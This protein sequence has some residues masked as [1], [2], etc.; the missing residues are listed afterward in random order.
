MAAAAPP[1]SPSPAPP[2]RAA[3]MFAAPYSRS[4]S[5]LGSAAKSPLADRTN[6]ILGASERE[7]ERKR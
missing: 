1:A 2:A 3:A 7:R 6:A 4:K 5:P